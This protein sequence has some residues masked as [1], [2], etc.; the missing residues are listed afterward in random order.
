MPAGALPI[1]LFRS[2]KNKGI[3]RIQ[4]ETYVVSWAQHSLLHPLPVDEGPVG[5]GILQAEIARRRHKD[6]GMKTRDFRILQHNLVLAGHPP[7][8]EDIS[9][10]GKALPFAG[11]GFAN[12]PR[13]FHSI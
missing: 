13:L 3:G 8:L 10:N 9:R 1:L 4:P 12:E 5:G 7:N 2:L 11:T 6:G